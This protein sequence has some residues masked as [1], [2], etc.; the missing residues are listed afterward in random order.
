MKNTD[1]AAKYLE[2]ADKST[3]PKILQFSSE[4]RLTKYEI[5]ELFA[6]IMGLPLEGM[7][8]LSFPWR[9]SPWSMSH[10]ITPFQAYQ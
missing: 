7:V 1:I 5:C 2:T 6:E 8:S 10:E 4:D 9:G 3:L